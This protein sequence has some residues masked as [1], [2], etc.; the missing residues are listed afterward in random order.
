MILD[1]LEGDPSAGCDAAAGC[2][3]FH[4]PLKIQLARSPILWHHPCNQL[5]KDPNHCFP[6]TILMDLD[7]SNG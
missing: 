5:T 3:L 6:T 7:T 4:G 1:G 2:F